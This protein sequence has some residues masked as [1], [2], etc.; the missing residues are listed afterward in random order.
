MP[1]GLVQEG[2]EN[3][4]GSGEG[5]F[6]KCRVCGDRCSSGEVAEAAAAGGGGSGGG[7]G[8]GH[9]CGG[10]ALIRG[11]SSTDHSYR[12]VHQ[13]LLNSFAI[14]LWSLK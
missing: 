9:V 4:S 14:S 3:Y 12:I 8:G 10:I 2:R 6:N 11:L 5:N 13:S 7:G 1:R